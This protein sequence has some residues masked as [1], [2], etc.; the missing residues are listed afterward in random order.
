M[1]ELL[2]IGIVVAM[3]YVVMLASVMFESQTYTVYG[4]C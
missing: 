4:H 3:L 1:S 2:A